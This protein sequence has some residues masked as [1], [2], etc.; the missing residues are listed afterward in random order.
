MSSEVGAEFVA[1]KT[2][3]I[4]IDTRALLDEGSPTVLEKLS[5][6]RPIYN[7]I[8]T[9]RVALR[10]PW[11]SPSSLPKDS[12]Q[13]QFLMNLVTAI[14]AL[15]GLTEVDVVLALSAEH[16]RFAYDWILPFVDLQF[17]DW[18]LSS[19]VRGQSQVPS[20]FHLTNL[21]KAYDRNVQRLEDEE[22]RIRR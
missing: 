8:Q 17:T 11:K 21:D 19:E 14:D 6:I 12:V 4:L 3:E 9:L 20:D 2:F 13:F 10:I 22:A 18:Q 7:N 16:C 1:N 5:N 15:G